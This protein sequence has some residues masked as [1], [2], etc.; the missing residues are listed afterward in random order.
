MLAAGVSLEKA[1]GAFA[2]MYRQDPGLPLKGAMGFFNDGDL[3]SQPQAD[4][5]LLRAAPDGVSDIPEL[6]LLNG[7]RPASQR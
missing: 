5:K 1:R 4:Q 6:R 7:L 3:P 2:K